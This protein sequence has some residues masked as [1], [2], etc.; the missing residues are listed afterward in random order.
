MNDKM[1]Q[2]FGGMRKEELDKQDAEYVQKLR[3]LVGMGSPQSGTEIPQQRQLNLPSNLQPRSAITSDAPVMKPYLSA[4][5]DERIKA[6]DM[7]NQIKQ[8]QDLEDVGAFEAP[9]SEVN[10][11]AAKLRALLGK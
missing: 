1:K 7:A 5:V 4:P 8:L 6:N 11:R 10:V 9:D 3:S 2:A